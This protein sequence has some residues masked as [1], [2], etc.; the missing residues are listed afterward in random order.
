MEV[1]PGILRVV[2]LSTLYRTDGYARKCGKVCLPGCECQHS[3]SNTAHLSCFTCH[4]KGEGRDYNYEL[5]MKGK[6]LILKLDD[7]SYI[8]S[9]GL[10]GFI[11]CDVKISQIATYNPRSAHPYAGMQFAPFTH[12]YVHN[13]LVVDPR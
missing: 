10:Y 13:V 1:A 7:K 3:E 2:S 11:L 4:S 9:F 5:R 12:P 6:K 8:F